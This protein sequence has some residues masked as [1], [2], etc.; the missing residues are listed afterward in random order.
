MPVKMQMCFS[1]GKVNNIKVQ[2]QDNT[3]PLT[4]S[5]KRAL[6]SVG[7]KNNYMNVIDLKKTKGGCGACGGR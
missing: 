4:G 7:N 5:G 3:L 6:F 2:R 1:N